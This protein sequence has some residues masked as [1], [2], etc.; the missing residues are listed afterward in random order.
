VEAM[1]EETPRK[2]PADHLRAVLLIVDQCT[3]MS[4]DFAL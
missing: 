4:N 3:Y 2:Q 1:A